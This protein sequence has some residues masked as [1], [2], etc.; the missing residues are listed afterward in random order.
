MPEAP[1]QNSNAVRRQSAA[2]PDL[3][4]LTGAPSQVASALAIRAQRFAELDEFEANMRAFLVE[5]GV[6]QVA[7]PTGEESPGAARQDTGPSRQHEQTNALSYLRAIEKVRFMTN[8]S[9]WVM[10]RHVPVRKILDAIR[11]RPLRVPVA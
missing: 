8:A 11:E 7:Q 1:V 6:G 2:S 5:L 3:P 9:W 10:N 4:T